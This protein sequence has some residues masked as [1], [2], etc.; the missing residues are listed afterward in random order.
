MTETLPSTI[1]ATVAI[2]SAGRPDR[3]ARCLEV[4]SAMEERP[5]ELIVI[6]QGNDVPTQNVA[7]SA[8]AHV[9]L[10]HSPGVAHAVQVGIAA[11]SSDVIA[12][13][14]DDAEA[15]VDWLTKIRA[16][17]ELNTQLGLLAGRDNVDGDRLAGDPD[18][19]VGLVRR[20]KVIGNHHLGQGIA[21]PA[22]HLK[23][24]NMS[25]RVKPARGIDLTRLVNGEGAQTAFELI[26]SL[27]ILA[28]GYVGLYDPRVQVDHFPAP[29]APGDE[30]TSY[31]RERVEIMKHNEAVAIG[32]Y[33]SLPTIISYVSR[34]VL[35]GDRI[36]CGLATHVA[37]RLGGD[38]EASSRHRGAMS[39]MLAGL[40]R[41]YRART[42]SW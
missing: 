30:R 22:H 33:A 6:A 25:M 13:I 11:A 23:G 39:G 4:L 9:V 24:A 16:A 1:T 34:S 42:S 10:V 37:L 36:C 7:Q 35:I 2:A 3:L 12:F 26:L 28:E 41:A 14:D 17:F 8:G 5:E 29:R 20:G 40:S 27:G 15:H 38:H 31:S 32:R 18:L 21:R 19:K